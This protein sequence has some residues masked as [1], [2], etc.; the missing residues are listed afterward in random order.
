MLLLVCDTCVSSVLGVEGRGIGGP[1]VAG[2]STPTP[3]APTPERE[4]RGDDSTGGGSGR[5][6][7]EVGSH[8]PS[9][10]PTTTKAMTPAMPRLRESTAT[11]AAGTTAVL[12]SVA[13][14]RRESREQR[15]ELAGET[16]TVGGSGVRKG[17][18]ATAAA[19]AVPGLL[20]SACHLKESLGQ[21]S[22]P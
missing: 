16:E 9:P 1:E 15:G 5:S 18:G 10:P 19:A 22:L 6:A 2:F 7:S 12:P 21:Q 17:R 13:G 11:P 8:L 20:C 14:G 3:V 4:P